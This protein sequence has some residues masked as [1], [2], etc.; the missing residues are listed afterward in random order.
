MIVAF[1]DLARF[2]KSSVE[3]GV[4]REET[5]VKTRLMSQKSAAQSQVGRRNHFTTKGYFLAISTQLSPW[6]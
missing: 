5:D 1:L 4:T 3:A 6:I 2:P